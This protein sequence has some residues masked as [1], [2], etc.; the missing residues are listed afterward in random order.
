MTSV[1][2]HFIMTENLRDKITSCETVHCDEHLSNHDPI[3]AKFNIGLLDDCIKTSVNMNK[4]Y[5]WKKATSEDIFNYM[6][7]VREQSVKYEPPSVHYCNDTLCNNDNHITE[8]D[9]YT[10]DIL[11]LAQS[12]ILLAQVRGKFLAG[13]LMLNL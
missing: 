11:S 4:K 8:L 10:L 13:N 6:Y 5:K 9:Q 12:T 1:L 7:T 3:R 2:D